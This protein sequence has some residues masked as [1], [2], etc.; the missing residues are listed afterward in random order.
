MKYSD[1]IKD[2]YAGNLWPNETSSRDNPNY[3]KAMEGFCKSEDWLT[4]NLTGESKK[5]LLHLINCHNS[6]IG[7]T[8]FENF[9]LGV[10][11]GAILMLDICTDDLADIRHRKMA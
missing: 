7:E 1:V 8:A 10:R 3:V 9:R 5:H 6:L 2:L 11:L 4:E